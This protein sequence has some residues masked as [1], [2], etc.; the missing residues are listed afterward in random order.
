MVGEFKSRKHRLDLPSIP[1]GNNPD[2]LRRAMENSN[3]LFMD[4]FNR[5]ADDYYDFKKAAFDAAIFPLPGVSTIDLVFDEFSVTGTWENPD[6]TE[7]TPTHVR[8]RILEIADDWAEYTYPITTWSF[9][10]LTPNTQYTFQVQLVARYETTESFVSTTRNCPS[11]P[12]LRVAESEIKSKVFTTLEGVGPPEDAAIDD[13]T[14]DFT[15]PDPPGG[16][17]G[18]VGSADCWWEYGFQYFSLTGLVGSFVD[19]G[20]TTSVAGGIGAVTHD[21]NAAPFSTYASG[22]FRMKYR[23]ICN[24]VPHAWIYT[25]TFAKFSISTPCGA[26]AASASAG[27]LPYSNADMFTVVPCM[28]SAHWLRIEDGTSHATYKQASPGYSGYA[29]TGDEWTVY[30]TDTTDTAISDRIHVPLLS[31]S[32]PAIGTLH[33]TSNFTFCIDIYLEALDLR[34]SYGAPQWRMLNIGNKINLSIVQNVFT[35]E[36][37]VNVPREGGGI[38]TFRASG[39]SPGVWNSF[40]YVHDVSITTGRVLYVNS[41]E[42]AR[43]VVGSND[44]DF[45]SIDD[46]LQINTF[47]SMAV[48]KVYG[49]KRAVSVAEIESGYAEGI[50]SGALGWWDASSYTSGNWVNQGTGGSVLDFI[51]GAAT[52]APSFASGEFTFDGTDDY[53]YVADNSLI[54]VASD[55]S[56]T[57]GLIFYPIASMTIGKRLMAKDPGSGVVYNIRL[58]SAGALTSNFNDGTT[59]L[60]T[61]SFTPALGAYMMAASVRSHDAMLHYTYYNAAA[62]TTALVSDNAINNSTNLQIGGATGQ[63]SN[64]KVKAAFMFKRALSAAELLAIQN[65]Y[66]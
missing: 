66:L 15:L 19:I 26:I 57:Y 59:T 34:M 51:L 63:F 18:A 13:T 10:G 14:I 41:V 20:S 33:S 2:V 1:K 25:P 27:S 9:A 42:I 28:A 54:D 55:E 53:M 39:L 7:V 38:Y 50:L 46:T 6:V 61:S 64:I 8:V 30:S 52:A 11:V 32:I 58:T 17:P 60:A 29:R 23:E 35:Y 44:N 21:L 22:V 48:R 45:D 56:I 40:F 16:T 65:Y 31:A 24:G 5:L 49:W 36:A 43:S 37:I 4:Q 62:V 12:V 47:N 3:R